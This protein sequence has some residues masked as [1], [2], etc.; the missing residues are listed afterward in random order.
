MLSG[1]SLINIINS[2]K[3]SSQFRMSNEIFKVRNLKR[4][5]LLLKFVY[6]INNYFGFMANYY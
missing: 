5:H 2:Q 4:M 3:V 6:N 1:M